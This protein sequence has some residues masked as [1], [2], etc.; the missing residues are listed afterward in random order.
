VSIGIA[1][2]PSDGQTVDELLFRADRAMYAAKGAGRDRVR[3]A[4][5]CFPAD[6]A[7]FTMIRPAVQ[8][9]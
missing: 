3:A 5:D 8:P 1:V 7:R 9:H 4:A 6:L 2:Y